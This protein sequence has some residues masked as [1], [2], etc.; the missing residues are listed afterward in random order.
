MNTP[1]AVHLYAKGGDQSQHT[2]YII[3]P[4]KLSVHINTTYM[5][6]KLFLVYAPLEGPPYMNSDPESFK[7]T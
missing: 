3:L 5:L 2:V 7:V 6:P 4:M 1:T